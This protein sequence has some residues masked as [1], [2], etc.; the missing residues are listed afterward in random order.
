G[1]S[2]RTP[3]GGHDLVILDAPATGHALGML[4]SP[5]TFGKIARVGP[6][7]R[8]TGHVRELLADPARTAYLAVAHGTEMAVTETIELQEGLQTALG[9]ELAAV[10]V[11]GLL[12]RRFSAPEMESLARL[13]EGNG[14]G[15]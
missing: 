13:A 6:I 5:E 2:G 7:V 12:P 10:V 11:N 4:R 9:R 1:R 14:G 8:D 3:R 15:A